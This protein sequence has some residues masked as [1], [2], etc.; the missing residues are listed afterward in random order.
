[1]WSLSSLLVINYF[2]IT[3]GFIMG[4]L[5]RLFDWICKCGIFDCVSI[6]WNLSRWYDIVGG[7]KSTPALMPSIF[8]NFFSVVSLNVSYFIF[9]ERFHWKIPVF[10]FSEMFHPKVLQYF[11]FVTKQEKHSI[12][13]CNPKKCECRKNPRTGS[14]TYICIYFFQDYWLRWGPVEI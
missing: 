14:I 3:H 4:I 5:N 7:W 11:F 12:V 9:I 1:M 13:I 10:Q 8:T 2:I 6:I